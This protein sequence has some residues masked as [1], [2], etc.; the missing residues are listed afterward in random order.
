MKPIITFSPIQSYLH[1]FI[2]VCISLS[3]L[4]CSK[5][6]LENRYAIPIDKEN[7]CIPLLIWNIRGAFPA[8]KS[9]FERNNPIRGDSSTLSKSTCQSLYYDGVYNP[10]YG[11]LDLK[12]VYNISSRDTIYGLHGLCSY[13]SCVLEAETCTCLYLETKTAMP[14]TLWLNGDT[15]KRKDIQG[16]NIYPI[17]L[18]RGENE[19]RVKVEMSGDD[20]SFEATVYDSLSVAQL[21]AEGQSCNIIYPLI[22]SDTKDIMVTNNHQN[23][24]SQPVCIFF[25]DVE[26]HEIYRVPLE[27]D[28][29]VYHVP[30]LKANTSYM[31]S[32]KVG[33][34][35]VRQPVLCGKDDDALIK[36]RNLKNS[37][38]NQHPRTNEIDQLLFRLDFL[39]NHPSRYEGDWWWQ[40]KIPPVTYQ[41]E[42]VFAHLNETYGVSDSEPNVNFVTYVSEQDDILQRYILVRPNHLEA[43]DVLP[44]VVIVRPF[45]EKLHHFFTSPQLARQWALNIVQG[46]SNHHNFLVM[47]P[48]ARMLKDEDLTPMAEKEIRLAIEDVKKHYNVDEK[49]IYL[50]ANCTGGYRALKLAEANPCMFSAIALYTPIYEI[51][52]SDEQS[53]AHTA[54]KEI[55]QLKGIPMMIH[56]DPLDEHS[57]YEQFRELIEDCKRNDIPLS[58]SVKRNSGKFYNVVIAGKEAF[59]FFDNKLNNK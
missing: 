9:S 37:I 30:A 50:Q 35:V 51:A 15:L 56:Y 58:I 6:H 3:L 48:E 33:N 12:E 43:D 8:Q 22:P 40:F 25:H 38:S 1:G 4:S 20:W 55:A 2:Y 18:R 45:C 13:L 31:C 23:V 57:S 47:M 42:H 36:F 34:T 59:E 52:F 10:S 21:Y 11:Q 39:L 14:A 16:L 26:G 46:L 54:R 44:L 17:K 53:K 29:N 27:Q 5:L 19:L 49:R 32:M 24:L 28:K 41:L 7:V